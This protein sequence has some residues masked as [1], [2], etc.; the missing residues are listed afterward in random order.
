MKFRTQVQFNLGSQLLKLERWD[1]ARQV[2]QRLRKV[3]AN[4]DLADSLAA[5]LEIQAG[6]YDRA[7]ALIQEA[8]A[9]DPHNFLLRLQLAEACARQNK[10][11]A[12][13]EALQ[14]AQVCPHPA[15]DAELIRQIRT[16]LAAAAR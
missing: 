10:T 13:L 11:A 9:I 1:G 4:G 6:R 16:Q 3:D 7:E 8:I 15:A 12:A 5:M 2:L 14:A